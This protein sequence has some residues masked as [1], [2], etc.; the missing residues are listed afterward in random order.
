M[1]THQFSEGDRRFLDTLSKDDALDVMAQ[2]QVRDDLGVGKKFTNLAE[3][4]EIRRRYYQAFGKRMPKKKAC[5][6]MGRGKNANEP[7]ISEKEYVDRAAEMSEEETDRLR[8][9]LAV[10][11]REAW[12]AGQG[13]RIGD[14]PG[15]QPDALEYQPKL[16]PDKSQAYMDQLGEVVQPNARLASGG[17]NFRGP[18]IRPD[19]QLARYSEQPEGVGRYHESLAEGRPMYGD[20]LRKYLGELGMDLAAFEGLDDNALAEV[21]RSIENWRSQNIEGAPEDASAEDEGQ[22]AAVYEK[23]KGMRPVAT[24]GTG[25]RPVKFS[26]SVTSGGKTSTA[27]REVYPK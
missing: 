9:Q 27:T 18:V 19:A 8:G 3:K 26:M 21:C 7:L 14:P 24:G 2:A 15:Q 23:G 25:K 6:G 4:K 5:F 11:D 12:F 22:D 1:A 20:E 13:R 17:S 16:P 10:A